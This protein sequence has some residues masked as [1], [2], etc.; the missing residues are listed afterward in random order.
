M[1]KFNAD[2]EE[3]MNLESHDLMRNWSKGK[4]WEGTAQLA[5]IIGD[6]LVLPKDS[7][8]A[9]LSDKNRHANVPIILGVNKDDHACVPGKQAGVS[10]SLGEAARKRAGG[11]LP[12][13]CRG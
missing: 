12:S 3:L 13:G 5:R 1:N 9:A 7:I 8:L 11:C 2:I 6:D 10:E 4:V